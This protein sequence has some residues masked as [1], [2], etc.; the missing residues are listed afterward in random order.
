MS[1]LK[2]SFV[3]PLFN[4]EN[5]ISETIS[6]ILGQTYHNLEIIIVDDGSTDNS[7]DIVKSICDDRII[8]YSQSNHGACKARNFGFSKCTGDLIQFFDSDDVISADYVAEKVKCF[9]EFG[10]GVVV[11]SK[12]YRF[13]NDVSNS[14]L[15]A[16]PLNRSYQTG[17]DLIIDMADNWKF[18]QV[19]A[20]MVSRKLYMITDGWDE[21]LKRNQDG[22]LFFRLLLVCEKVVFSDVPKSFYRLTSGS[23]TTGGGAESLRSFLYSVD[24]YRDN[25]LMIEDSNRTRLAIASFY[26]NLMH[27]TVLDF[28]DITEFIMF[29]LG[30][31]NQKERIGNMFFLN[32]VLKIIG[33]K[34]LMRLVRLIKPIKR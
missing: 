10:L 13:K 8:V 22:D 18:F 31:L 4:S 9:E 24:K 5:F 30:E 33:F 1:N 26:T 21:Y 7:L 15:L 19:S 17:I 23:I 28:P 20:W 27:L 11:T 12:H 25:L 3:I 14:F 2:V 6:S 29:R 34:N 16:K 32:L